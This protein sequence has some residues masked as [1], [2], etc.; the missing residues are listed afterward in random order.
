ME[1]QPTG[2][3]FRRLVDCAP[4]FQLRADDALLIAC[5]R[6]LESSGSS[7]AP[8]DIA[9]VAEFVPLTSRAAKILGV[10]ARRAGVHLGVPRFEAHFEDLRRIEQHR[11][12]HRSGCRLV[13]AAGLEL[14]AS[15]HERLDIIADGLRRK[16]A[17]YAKIERRRSQAYFGWAV[18]LAKLGEQLPAS[19]WRELRRALAIEDFLKSLQGRPVLRAPVATEHDVRRFAERLR[20]ACREAGI[21]DC[22][23]CRDSVTAHWLDTLEMTS[24]HAIRDTETLRAFGRDLRVVEADEGK[25]DAAIVAYCLGRQAQ[26]ETVSKLFYA[27]RAKELPW[28]IPSAPVD[29][30]GDPDVSIASIPEAPVAVD[31]AHEEPRPGPQPETLAKDAEVPAPT[32]VVTPAAECAPDT[33]PTPGV[34]ASTPLEGTVVKAPALADRQPSSDAAV[35]EAAPAEQSAA[36]EARGERRDDG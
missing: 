5:F 26:T 2:E 33:L 17:A 23:P 24:G 6:D 34:S 14:S 18:A 32:A 30:M 15:T 25:E 16:P 20:Q 29:W 19:Q 35:S 13:E 3:T 9:C 7:D 27:Q 31:T 28:L 12:A 8:V 10:D 21:A 1:P 11:H 36:S 4:S 22:M